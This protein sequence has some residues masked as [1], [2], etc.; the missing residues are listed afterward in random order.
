MCPIWSKRPSIYLL[1]APGLWHLAN[2]GA[3][4]WAQLAR[5]AA[6][7]CGVNAARVRPCSHRELN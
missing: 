6:R 2:S 7:E 5:L 3:M 4:N 1:M